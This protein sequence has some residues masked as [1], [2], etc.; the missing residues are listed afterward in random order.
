MWFHEV[1]RFVATDLTKRRVDEVRV[2]AYYS[3][4]IRR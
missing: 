1:N 3:I 4:G 2:R